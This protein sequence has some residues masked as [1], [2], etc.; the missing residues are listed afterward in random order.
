M[1]H[2][3]YALGAVLCWASLPA[4]TGSGLEELSIDELMFYSFGSAALYL[5]LQDVILKKSF[6]LYIPS[7][8]ISLLG[9]WGIFLYHYFYYVALS[10]VPL[11]QGAILATTWSFWIV[12]FS[13]LLF[14]R[15]L[16]FSIL[17]T[18]A[19]GMF[20][21]ALVI[22]S[23]K[24]LSFS[25]EYMLGYFLAL[26]CGLIW[27]SFSVV[28]GRFTVKKEVMTSFTL[29]AALLSFGL[30]LGGERHVLP[31][32]T[33]LFSAVYL[34]C[35]PLGLSFFLW[36]RAIN[37][38]NM[39]IIGFLSYLAPPLAVLL[40]SLIHGEKVPL[41]VIVG[42][43]VIIAASVSGKIILDRERRNGNN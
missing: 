16:K 30:F 43:L 25:S 27:S 21:A 40:V 3:F 32:A 23:G 7:L 8:K 19:L 31:S 17:L 4:A 22:A 1:K 28:L 42:M 37:G 20:G 9:V 39:M 24:E 2:Y 36:N 41:Q 26:L 38:G 5:Y 34:G 18:A 12:F 35:V 33:A 6:A 15:R 10:Y 29:Y 14:F 11:A 13:S